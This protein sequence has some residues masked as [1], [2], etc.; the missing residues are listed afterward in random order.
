[1]LILR[2]ILYK[3]RSKISTKD[4]QKLLCVVPTQINALI[5]LANENY[6][7]SSPGRRNTNGKWGGERGKTTEKY[8]MIRVMYCHDFGASGWCSRQ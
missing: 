4:Q 1:M 8:L 5:Q 7:N 6:H 3:P 2:S